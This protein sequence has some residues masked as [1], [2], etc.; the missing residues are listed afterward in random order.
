MRVPL[1]SL[2]AHQD[3]L[4]FRRRTMSTSVDDRRVESMAP[5]HIS[6]LALQASQPFRCALAGPER[7]S[8]LGLGRSQSARAKPTRSTPCASTCGHRKRTCL[9]FYVISPSTT[10]IIIVSSVL[11]LLLLLLLLSPLYNVLLV[12]PALDASR[13]VLSLLSTRLSLAHHLPSCGTI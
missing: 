4:A 9:H 11:C 13:T 5:S 3:R 10:T 12:S 2:F 6:A 1:I 7:G 8:A